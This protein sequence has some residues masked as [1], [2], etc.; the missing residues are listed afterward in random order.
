M[1]LGAPTTGASA[2]P[3]GDGDVIKL[4]DSG[5]NPEVEEVLGALSLLLNG[6]GVAQLKLITQ[7]LNK[8]LTGREDA[9][10]SVL[11]QIES[12]TGTLADNKAD[13]V[14]AIEA[15][16]RLA[17]A[18]RGQQDDINSALDELPSALTSI[19]GQRADLVKMLQALNELGDVGVRVIKASKKPRSTRSPSCSR[20]SP[21][22]PTPVTPSSRP[23]TSS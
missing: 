7:E 6:G 18:T 22:S 23:S 10:R 16:D 8:A 9:A 5:R 20:C 2:E 4:A 1:S 12:F 14:D 11:T 21:S 17:K 19:D 3:L 13:I 15:L